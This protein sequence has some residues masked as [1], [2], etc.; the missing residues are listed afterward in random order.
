MIEQDICAVLENL[1][2]AADLMGVDVKKFWEVCQILQPASGLSDAIDEESRNRAEARLQA[3]RNFDGFGYDLAG[4]TASSG[5]CASCGG[6]R[7]VV[8]KSASDEAVV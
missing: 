4:A 7:Q 8:V 5:P 1:Q 2:Q 6:S 3:V